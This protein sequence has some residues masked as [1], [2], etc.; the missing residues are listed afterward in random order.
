MQV[1]LVCFHIVEWLFTDR[2]ARQ[3]GLRQHIPPPCDTGEKLHKMDLRGRAVQNW[4]QKHRDFLELWDRR[5]Q[6]LVHG[7]QWDGIM[8]YHDPYMVWYRKI[9]RRW[10]GKTGGFHDFMVFFLTCVSV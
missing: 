4:V 1:P 10:I 8:D 9:T 3:F 6:S 2:V 7:A 5:R